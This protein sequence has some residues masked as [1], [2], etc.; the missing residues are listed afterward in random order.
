MKQKELNKILENHEKWANRDVDNWEDLK[1]DLS[2]ENLRGADL[3]STNLRCVDLRRADLKEANLSGANLRGADLR[4]AD[5]S[6]ANLYKADLSG[7]N[8]YKADL[9]GANLYKADLSGADLFMTDLSGA[10]LRRADL[11]DT[12]LRSANLHRA[13]LQGADLRGVNLKDADLSDVIK[14]QV[15]PSHGAFIGWKKAT[16][17]L[18]IKIMI[19]ENAKRLSAFSRKCRCDKALVLDIQNPNGESAN[20]SIAVSK[21][22]NKFKYEIGKIVKVDDFDN[23]RFKEC[24]PGIHFFVTREEAVEYSL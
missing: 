11:T 16:D 22:D 6:G 21:Y 5:L 14:Y 1:I 20:T 19:L 13:D 7:A 18:I 24:A 15:P 2:G 12:D 8:L 10:Y 9:S 4:R 17:N 23:N 3:S